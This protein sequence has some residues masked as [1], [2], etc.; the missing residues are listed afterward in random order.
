VWHGYHNIS[1][2]VPQAMACYCAAGYARVEV[3]MAAVSEM[4]SR[5]AGRVRGMLSLLTSVSP[6]L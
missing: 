1:L 4:M 2:C 3:I 5:C 6:I